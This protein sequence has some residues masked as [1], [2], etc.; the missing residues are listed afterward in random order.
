MDDLAGAYLRIQGLKDGEEALQPLHRS[1]D[2]IFDEATILPVHAHFI[3]Q[4]GKTRLFDLS[5]QRCD[6][7]IRYY[8]GLAGWC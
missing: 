6:Q 5:R 3:R 7:I 2:P 8:G 4:Q 1:A